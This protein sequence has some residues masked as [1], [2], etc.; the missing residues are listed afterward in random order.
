[1]CL[2][3]MHTQGGGG[4]GGGGKMGSK[5]EKYSSKLLPSV[6]FNLVLLLTLLFL[7]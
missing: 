1:M 5:F 6:T 4:G 3:F 7:F 2:G